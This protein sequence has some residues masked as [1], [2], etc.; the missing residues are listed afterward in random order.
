MEQYTDDERV[1]DLKKWWKENGA[2]ILIGIALGVMA[3]FGWQ[4]WGTHRNAQA[5]TA[6]RAYDAFIEAVEKPDPDQARQRGQTL[7]TDFPKSPYATLAALRLAKL[8]VDR[9]DD[10]TAN[11][12]LEWVISNAQLDEFKDIARLRLARVKLASQPVEAEKLLDSVTT[13]SLSAERE[14][15]KGDLYLNGKNPDKART[16]YTAA[17]AASG[18][19]PLLQLKLDNLAVATPETVVAAPAAPASP[20][21]PAPSVPEPAQPEA[22]PAPAANPA[23]PVPAPTPPAVPTE[24]QATAPTE[25]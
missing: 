25:P 22:P 15:L 3:I 4:Y 11:Q 13:T 6:S 5:E 24:P 16:A 12:Q 10:A 20:P 14:E 8:A 19:N 23:E 1:E 2:S 9:S 7:T 18:G 21:P 17:L